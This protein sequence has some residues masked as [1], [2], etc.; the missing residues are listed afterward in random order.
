M[1]YHSYV[2]YLLAILRT[3]I[4]RNIIPSDLKQLTSPMEKINLTDGSGEKPFRTVPNAQQL[5]HSFTIKLL[6]I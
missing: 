1:T 5:I 4:L 6:L 2:Y 3:S